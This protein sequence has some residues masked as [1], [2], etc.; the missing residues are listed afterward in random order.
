MHPGWKS[1]TKIRFPRTGNEQQE[2][3]AQDLVF[4]V[5]EMLDD[6]FSREGNDSYCRVRVSLVEALAGRN[7]GGKVVETVELLDGRKMQVAAPLGVIKPGQEQTIYGGGIPIRKDGSVKK[8][9]DMNV[10]WEVVFPD[11]WTLSFPS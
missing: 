2:G 3:E 11:R 9:G 4:V 10:K 8:K 7:D 1:G 5:E 6:V